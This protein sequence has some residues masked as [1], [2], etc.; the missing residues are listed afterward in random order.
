MS[1]F[2]NSFWKGD[3]FYIGGIMTL[4]W[5]FYIKPDGT[6]LYIIA[7]GV[8]IL[9]EFDFIVDYD[10]ST[11]ILNKSFSLAYKIS[12][13]ASVSFS[14][15]GLV[16]FVWDNNTRD[17]YK[18]DLSTAWDISTSV[19]NS[20][21]TIFTTTS[22][23][24]SMISDGTKIYKATADLKTVEQYSLT[25]KDV[26]TISLVRTF[27][28]TTLG[29]N[30]VASGIFVSDDGTTMWINE[31]IENNIRTL[32]MSTPYD[33]STLSLT[34]TKNVSSTN[35]WLRGLFV[36]NSRIYVSGVIRDLITSYAI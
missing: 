22:S 35:S 7:K 30:G 3:Y 12:F 25:P 20:N 1:T 36:I 6:K 29:I 24:F 32:S 16:Y 5:G 34:S 21:T 27:N 26:S 28:L 13:A 33:I 17:W 23:D 11:L 4:P 15:D 2:I 10:I 9:Y 14:S 8:D 19:F 18:W 31:F